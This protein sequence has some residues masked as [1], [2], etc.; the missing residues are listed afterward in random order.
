MYKCGEYIVYGYNGVCVIEDITHL[1]MTGID[2]NALY[3]VLCP[4][5]S[6][7]SKLYFP[8][9]NAKT[10]NR[11]IM[12]KEEA[13]Q[14]INDIENTEELWIA[15]H[16]MR[17]ELYKSAMKTCDCREWIRI[18]KTLYGKRREKQSTGKNISASDERFLKHA[19]SYMF[20]ELA[21]SL[22]ISEQEI[23]ELIEQKI[24][25]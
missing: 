14:F 18:I 25:R 11:R 21:L 16:K 6:P 23:R 17:E 4:L 12:T 20:S 10:V 9:D 2:Q 13:A 8:V 7:E 1:E 3:Y 24:S 15:N 22:Q 19:E 5:Q